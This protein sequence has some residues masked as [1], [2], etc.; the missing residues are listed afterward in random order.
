M[1]TFST[2]FNLVDIIK[3]SKSYN[4]ASIISDQVIYTVPEG[5]YASVN[6]ISASLWA[7]LNLRGYRPVNSDNVIL[8]SYIFNAQ[9]FDPIAPDIVTPQQIT[10]CLISNDYIQVDGTT[11]S[12]SNAT[13]EI[14]IYLFKNP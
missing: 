14:L 2:F 3:I 12:I 13:V 4:T 8:E 7:F 9:V 10:N 11:T 1:A 6:V 5:Y